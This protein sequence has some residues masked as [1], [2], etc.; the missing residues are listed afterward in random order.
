MA[1]KRVMC[2]QWIKCTLAPYVPCPYC[3]ETPC[4]LVEEQHNGR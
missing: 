2:S 1:E 4:Q 3:R